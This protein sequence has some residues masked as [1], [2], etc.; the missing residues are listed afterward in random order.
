F[1]A[2]TYEKGASVVRMIEHY[3]GPQKFRAGV[4]SYIRRHRE[5]NAVAADLWRALEQASGQ[6]VAQVAKAWI[7][8]PG[9]PLISLSPE[10]R[11]ESNGIAVKQERFLASPITRVPRSEAGAWPVPLVVKVAPRGDAVP[12]LERTLV[13]AAR[14]RIAVP[15]GKPPIWYYGN[16]SEGGF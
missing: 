12:R 1:D 11:G 13:R 10:E 3:L 6:P 16:A 15:G 9:F 14:G 7:R 8:Q 5:S 2:I 4:R